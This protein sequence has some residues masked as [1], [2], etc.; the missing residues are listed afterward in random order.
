MSI[1]TVL[2]VSNET[3]RILWDDARL[4]CLIFSLFSPWQS[5]DFI[6][7]DQTYEVVI[8]RSK[9]GYDLKTP[10]DTTFCRSEGI[11][12]AQ[13]EYTLTLLSQNIFN[14]YVQIHASCVDLNGNGALLVGHH[15][16]GKTTLALA[17]LSNG[18][19]ALTDDIAVLSEDFSH[20][21]GFPRPFKVTDSTWN[22]FSSFVPKVCPFMRAYVDL[23]YVFFYIPS[24][25]Y[26]TE[27][28]RLKCV[29]FPV[30]QSGT[31]KINEIGETEAMRRILPQGFNFNLRKDAI[32]KNLLTLLRNTRLFEIAYSDPRDAIRKL[33]VILE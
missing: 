8:R 5:K 30:W 20:V 9:S 7:T 6:Q 33:R 23:T 18:F 17:A 15:G 24:G 13:L 28:T 19:K 21:T 10:F 4:S 26:Y 31:T 3:I 32:I 14:R 29:V 16:A 11:L 27:N 2:G 25:H 1:K 12:L 22:A